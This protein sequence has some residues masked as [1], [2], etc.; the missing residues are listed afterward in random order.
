MS[1]ATACV[2]GNGEEERLSRARPQSQESCRKKRHLWNLVFVLA[3]APFRAVDGGLSLVLGLNA[4]LAG[5][6]S[7]RILLSLTDHLLHLII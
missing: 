7:F 1:S 3:Q 2:A 6:V 4:R 5:L